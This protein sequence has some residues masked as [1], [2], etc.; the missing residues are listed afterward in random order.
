MVALSTWQDLKTDLIR[1]AI[2]GSLFINPSTT[3]V[4]TAI[5]GTSSSELIAFPA[6][7][8][9]AGFMTD[10]GMQWARSI[11][12]SEVTSF[13]Q[14]TPT[15]SDVTTDTETVQVNFQQCSALTI[16]M[17]TGAT[18]ASLVPDATTGELQ[19]TKPDAPPKRHYQAL[20]MAVDNNADGDIYICK[21]FPYATVTDY[22]DQAFAKSDDA[23][24]WGVTLRAE[25]HPTAQYAVRWIF[26]GPGFIALAA[27]M[28]LE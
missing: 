22:A 20:G 16:A 2:G 3:T 15:R 7:W 24:N 21:Y 28:G 19:I 6:G 5:T 10:D 4:L 17:F 25:K 14:A 27:A 1:K 26:G 12:L 11:E 9:D 13:G 23:I 18:I 8:D